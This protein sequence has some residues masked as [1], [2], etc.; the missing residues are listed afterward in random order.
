MHLLRKARAVDQDH[1]LLLS[2][3]LCP[4][5]HI[6]QSTPIH[7]HFSLLSVVARARLGRSPSAAALPTLV[8]HGPSESPGGQRGQEVL[9]WVLRSLPP[10]LFKEVTDLMA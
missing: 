6:R 7:Q 4:I 5:A 2:T 1:R 9:T 8:L 3:S 10:E